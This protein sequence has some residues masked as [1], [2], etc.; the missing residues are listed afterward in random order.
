[1]GLLQHPLE[2]SIPRWDNS[3]FSTA[4]SDYSRGRPL[5]IN[6]KKR[7]A[8][9]HHWNLRQTS[10]YET[11]LLD[12]RLT[13]HNY[14]RKWW[15]GRTRTPPSKP[16]LIEVH[17]NTNQTWDM[18]TKIA[19]LIGADC[20]LS[21]AGVPARSQVLMSITETSI[22]SGVFWGESILVMSCSSVS[23]WGMTLGTSWVQLA[24]GLM[25]LM[26]DTINMCLYKPAGTSYCDSGLS[27]D[28]HSTLSLA[29]KSV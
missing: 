1:M 15:V 19:P 24:L 7:Y 22:S 11:V 2:L 28:T 27:N 14:R 4:F 8:L 3:L 20:V 10:D 29:H 25:A 18:K 6:P 16:P 9:L 5:I 17:A 12:Y 26:H 13:L 23:H 21:A